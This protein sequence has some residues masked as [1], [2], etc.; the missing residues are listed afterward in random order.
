M[1]KILSALTLAT[2]LATALAATNA[3]AQSAPARI[4]GGML[5]GSNGMTLYVFDKDEGGK[6]ACNGKCAEN[7]PPLAALDGDQAVGDLSLISREDGRKQW[8]WKGKPVYFW[9]KDQ[10]PGDTTG[11]GFNGVWHVAR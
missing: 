5:V 6:S 9:S 11:D 7:W 3:H 2:A 10:K 1:N 4:L 8:A